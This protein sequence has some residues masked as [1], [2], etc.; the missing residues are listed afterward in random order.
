MNRHQRENFEGKRTNNGKQS[1][2]NK[3]GSRVSRS[4][5]FCV[6]LVCKHVRHLRAKKNN[7]ESYLA[8]TRASSLCRKE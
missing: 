4:P 8:H 3:K 2:K 7:A 6:I 5:F 1:F